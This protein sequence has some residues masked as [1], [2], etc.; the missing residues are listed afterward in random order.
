GRGGQGKGGAEGVVQSPSP[1]GRAPSV[2]MARVVKVQ[3]MSRQRKTPRLYQPGGD[4][5]GPPAASPEGAQT[6][7]AARP[8][9]DP[10]K[11]VSLA[12]MVLRWL[13]AQED[14]RQAP[15][16]DERTRAG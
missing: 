12:E 9:R 5:P 1:S 8:P 14:S 6:P 3:P 11:L 7:A 13:A 2:R 16:A 15:P 10:T 4:S